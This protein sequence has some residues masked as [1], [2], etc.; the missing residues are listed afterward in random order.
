MDEYIHFIAE[1]LS[2]VD[3]FNNQTKYMGKIDIR[4]DS[5]KHFLEYVDLVKLNIFYSTFT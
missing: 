3:V 1:R 5:F 4:R 2:N